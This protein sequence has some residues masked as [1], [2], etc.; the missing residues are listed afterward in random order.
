MSYAA[1]KTPPILGG[2]G[3]SDR[4]VI[5]TNG[6]VGIDNG[7][8]AID[9]KFQVFHNGGDG[10]GG[11]TQIG[12]LNVAASGQ[13][14]IGCQTINGDLQSNLLLGSTISGTNRFWLVSKR[15]STA[16]EAHALRFYYYNGSTFSTPIVSM[17][18]NGNVGINVTNPLYKLDVGGTA[19]ISND[20]GIGGIPDSGARLYV[21]GE[22]LTEPFLSV[23]TCLGNNSISTTT[24]SSLKGY[25]AVKIGNNVG[26]SGAL[27]TAGTYYIRLWGTP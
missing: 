14:T 18:T 22:N 16:G 26:V 27:I 4:F 21:Q 23:Q 11:N 9:G 20:V 7:S 25:L 1:S 17:E 5:Q 6:R 15:A 19:R 2:G 12:I 10:S 24:F 13:S 3:V 8:V